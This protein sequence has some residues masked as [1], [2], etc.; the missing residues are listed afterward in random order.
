MQ[1]IEGSLDR[2]AM[3]NQLCAIN[4]SMEWYS[5]AGWAKRIVVEVRF[6]EVRELM[7]VYLQGGV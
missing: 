1:A 5:C 3:I 6:F 7:C 4:I 2:G